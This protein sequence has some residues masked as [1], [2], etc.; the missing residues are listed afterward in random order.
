MKNYL[1]ASAIRK[2]IAPKGSIRA[3]I[4][5]GN[6][7]LAQRNPASGRPEG[8]SVQLAEKLASELKVDLELRT[9]DSAGK[10]V[11]ALEDGRWDLA[12]LANDPGRASTICFTEPYVVIEGGYLV[13]VDS[14][15]HS[16]EEV[17]REGV[18]I[19]VGKNAAYDLFLS[20]T[21]QKAQL[22]RASTTPG[23]VDLFIN[24][25]L[26]IAAGVMSPLREFT[27]K[28]SGFRILEESFMQINQAIGIPIKAQAAKPYL[29]NFI[30][31]LINDGYVKE[32]LKTFNQDPH[33]AI[34]LEK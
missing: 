9:F 15:F 4:N 23:A 31:T 14:P 32:Q 19:A 6:S 8:V 21:L 18:R 17:D 30:K 28:N 34:S 11:E 10:V 1:R 33:I 20:R 29:D 3:A 27:L 5:L 16:I 7:V 22:V 24:E 13:R 26:E 12:F 2:I 25:N